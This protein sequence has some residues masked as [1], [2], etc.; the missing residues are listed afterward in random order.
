VTILRDILTY[1]LLS[2]AQVQG[3]ASGA[4]RLPRLPTGSDS[5]ILVL[6]AGADADRIVLDIADG[7]ADVRLRSIV[8]STTELTDTHGEMAPDTPLRFALAWDTVA[9]VLRL[10]VSG[11]PN[12]LTLT[13]T[14]PASITQMGVGRGS[15]TGGTELNG[16]V[17][18]MSVG[19][20]EIAANTLLSLVAG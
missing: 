19:A 7:T 17:I 9:G 20:G 12:V 3:Y 15:N 8:S 14:L 4:V 1:P 13:G 18:G 6:D 2:A 11:M 10:A 5:G 16:E